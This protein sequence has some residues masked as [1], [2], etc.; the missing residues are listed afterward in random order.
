[1]MS[2]ISAASAEQTSGIQQVNQAIGQMDD[3]T[4]QNAALAEQ[5]AAAE[6]LEEQAQSLSNTIAQFK[7][8]NFSRV[9]PEDLPQ[10]K[11]LHAPLSQ[12]KTTLVNK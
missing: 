6:S 4:Q 7:V 5:A 9:A 11:S 1:M 3:V 12:R 2:Q 8:D 10:G